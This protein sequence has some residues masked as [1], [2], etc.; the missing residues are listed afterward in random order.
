MRA[1]GLRRFLPSFGNGNGRLEHRADAT[2]ELLNAYEREALGVSVSPEDLAT[3]EAC[4]GLYERSIASA[5]VEPM[6]AALEAVS[7]QLLALAGRGLALFGQAVFLIDVDPVQG[8]TLAPSSSWDVQGGVLE[9]DWLYR[10]DMIGPSG[11]RTVTRPA[12]SVLHFRIGADSRAPWRGRPPLRR[13]QATA[14]LAAAIEAQLTAESKLPTGRIVPLS[15]T[16]EQVKKVG[17]MI[18]RGGITVTGLGQ[19]SP[20]QEQVPSSR[21]QPQKLGPDP[22]DAFG[23]L[24]RHVA[25]DIASAFGVPPSLFNPAGDGSGQREAWRRFWAGTIAPIGSLLEAEIRAKLDPEAHISFPALRASDED[26]RSR[27][28]ARRANA[29]K[30]FLEA[31]LDRE[32]ALRLAGLEL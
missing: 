23:Q 22:A 10:L 32:A 15:G 3:V 1:S 9:R 27:A 30:T 11:S 16:G 28:V 20:G 25:E 26:G 17:S 2:V 7:P 31:G 6:G 29:L 13:S 5:A 19:S 4:S 8:L 21:Y 14:N 18:A 12:A 24:R